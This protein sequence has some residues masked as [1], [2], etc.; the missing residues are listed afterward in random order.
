MAPSGVKVI[1][2]GRRRIENRDRQIAAR[3]NTPNKGGGALGVLTSNGNP[4]IAKPTP[5]NAK[6]TNP[7]CS[8]TPGDRYNL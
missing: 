7:S 5:A 1:W 3:K 4:I 8:F 6:A 2:C